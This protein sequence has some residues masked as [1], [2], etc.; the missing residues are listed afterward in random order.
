MRIKCISFFACIII[1]LAGITLWVADGGTETVV[2]TEYLR[3]HI[4][5]N[6]NEQD[7]QAVKLV[8]RDRVVDYLAPYIA[9][10]DTKQEAMDM[11]TSQLGS[12]EEIANDVLV[13]HGYGYTSRASIKREQF[14][15]RIYEGVTLDAG[16]Y[17]ALIIELGSAKGDNWWCVVYPP[18]CFTESRV[19]Y[20][21]KSKIYEIIEQ[22][23][24][25]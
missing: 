13:E 17:D 9:E 7:E 22:F 15:T 1:V 20:Q 3:M 2:T 18:L 10:C 16:I 11:L 21:Y 8:I 12:V 5:A 19:K 23:F 6:S 14:P 4:R 25:R 24:N